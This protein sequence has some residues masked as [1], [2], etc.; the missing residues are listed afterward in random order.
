MVRPIC[1]D[2]V[3]REQAAKSPQ[4][5]YKVRIRVAKDI[6]MLNAALTGLSS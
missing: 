5:R 2:Q 4:S 3:G 6:I 1:S